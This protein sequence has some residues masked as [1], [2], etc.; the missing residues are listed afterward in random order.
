MRLHCRCGCKCCWNPSSLAVHCF[1]IFRLED[2]WLCNP[3]KTTT[4]SADCEDWDSQVGDEI[5]LELSNC[6]ARMLTNRIEK[7]GSILSFPASSMWTVWDTTLG[8]CRKNQ[9]WPQIQNAHQAHPCPHITIMTMSQPFKNEYLG[10][11]VMILGVK[12]LP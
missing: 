6:S 1:F 12:K 4:I 3:R 11:L 8:Y 7:L 2:L 9:C 10:W 5:S